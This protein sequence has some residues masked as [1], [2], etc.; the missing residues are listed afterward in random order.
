MKNDD[1]DNAALIILVLIAIL[2]ACVLLRGTYYG[3]SAYSS[4]QIRD[5]EYQESLQSSLVWKYV[6]IY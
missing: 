1:F 5:R 6:E 4:Y 3:N 2:F